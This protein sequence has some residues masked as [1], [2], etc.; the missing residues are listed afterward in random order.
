MICRNTNQNTVSQ[1]TLAIFRLLS[2]GIIVVPYIHD[3]LLWIIQIYISWSTLVYM[4]ISTYILPSLKSFSIEGE[5]VVE[6]E[7][8]N[9]LK[10]YGR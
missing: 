8:Y 1:N 10:L 5:T 3:A 2:V 6:K 9:K 4:Y 7:G